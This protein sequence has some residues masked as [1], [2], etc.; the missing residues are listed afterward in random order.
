MYLISNFHVFLK[1]ELKLRS[2]YFFV[3]EYFQS[4]VLNQYITDF[5]RQTSSKWAKEDLLMKC[6]DLN[7]NASENTGI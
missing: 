7:P 6:I 5:T 4:V 1:Y 2:T 3:I